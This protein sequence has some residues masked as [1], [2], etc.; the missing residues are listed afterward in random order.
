MTY[1]ELKSRV[2]DL[3]HEAFGDV[4]ITPD[5]KTYGHLLDLAAELRGADMS[6]TRIEATTELQAFR[7]TLD[8]FFAAIPE[9]YEVTIKR[10]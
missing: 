5:S 9:G 8:D 7:S 6:A 3:S 4:A 2:I 1:D 10:G